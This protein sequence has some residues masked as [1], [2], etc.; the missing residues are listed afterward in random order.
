MKDEVENKLNS[1]PVMFGREAV[2]QLL[3]GVI[4]AG[5][6][7]NLDSKGEGPPRIR[8]GRKIC[9]FRDDFISWLRK[10]ATLLV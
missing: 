2:P 1:L 3:T 4:S 10:R 5:Y 7:R 6:L 9:Y 8:I